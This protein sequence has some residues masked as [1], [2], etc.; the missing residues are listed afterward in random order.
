MSDIVTPDMNGTFEITTAAGT[1]LLLELTEHEGHLTRRPGMVRPTGGSEPARLPGDFT[2]LE[3]VSAPQIEVGKPTD[4]CVLVN[5]EE[6]CVST[7]IVT[8]IQ[9]A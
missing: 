5:D 7:A 3:L 2:R 1:E 4:Y 9:E 8:S 6:V